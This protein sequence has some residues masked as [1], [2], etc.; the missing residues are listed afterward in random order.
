MNSNESSSPSGK[1]RSATQFF[2]SSPFRDRIF[3][4]NTFLLFA[5]ATMII[6]IL[7]KH[8]SELPP[9]ITLY[10]FVVMIGLIST[11]LWTLRAHRDARMFVKSIPLNG[12]IDTTTVGN[13]LSIAANL[14][15]LGLFYTFL[16]VGM[17]LM[18]LGEAI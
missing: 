10:L 7:A 14:T 13:A 1:N 16:L 5:D 2:L 9:R 11:W 17:C 18:A 3:V 15:H 8:W 4:G 12:P 6:V